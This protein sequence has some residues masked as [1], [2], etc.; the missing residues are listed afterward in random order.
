MKLGS[1][2]ACL[3]RQRRPIMLAAGFFDGIHRG[4]LAII[5]KIVSAAR[6]ERGAAWVMTFDTHPLKVLYP[7]AAP[8]LLTSTRTSS[9]C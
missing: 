4:H 8:R 2:L 6:R 9:D 5:R 1:K 3:R 7:K